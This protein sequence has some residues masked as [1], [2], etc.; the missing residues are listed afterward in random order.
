MLEHIE[1]DEEDATV[2]KF[3]RIVAH[4]GP[5]I[6]SHPNYKGSTYNVMVEWED[7]QVTSEPLSIIGADD[8]VTCTMYGNEHDL[9]DLPGWKWFKGIV[10][11][12]KKL[13]CMVK[14]AKLR[15]YCTAP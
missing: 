2:W 11:R 4:E 6:P 15:S 9:L 10:K 12:Q 14:Q 5:L 1:R 8:P 7:G 3:R 13:L